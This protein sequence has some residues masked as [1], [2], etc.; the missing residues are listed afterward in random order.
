M[1]RSWSGGLLRSEFSCEYQKT[2][3][4][5]L[6]CP[7]Q[8]NVLQMSDCNAGAAC[9]ERHIVSMGTLGETVLQPGLGATLIRTSVEYWCKEF[10]IT[11]LCT[12][13]TQGMTKTNSPQVHCV[14]E[15]RIIHTFRS[16]ARAPRSIFVVVCERGCDDVTQRGAEVQQRE[17]CLRTRK[18]VGRREKNEKKNSRHL[19]AHIGWRMCRNCALIENQ[20]Q[21]SVCCAT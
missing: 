21:S 14:Q 4:A 12:H 15:V 9:I 17:R 11:G 6:Q 18:G 7:I 19:C 1:E 13:S 3:I 10:L 20:W 2:F 8:N 5:R 16:A